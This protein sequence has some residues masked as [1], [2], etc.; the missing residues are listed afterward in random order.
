MAG[1][2]AIL[3][4]GSP[5]LN[6]K[7]AK[8]LQILADFLVD[9]VEGRRFAGVVLGLSGGID[10]AVS[11]AVAARALGP[12]RVTGLFMPYSQS[13][14]RSE[15]DVV[16]LAGRL[17]IELVKQP[18]TPF[19][20]CFFAVIPQGS[21]VRKGNVL[22]RLRMIVLFDWSHK[23]KR[24]VLG[25]SNK[26]E[27][28]L[29]YGTWY[30]DTACSM[31]AIGDLYKTQVRQLARYLRIPRSILGKT[32]SAD[33]W[34]GQTDEGEIGMSYALMDGILY[35]LFDMGM[36]PREVQE[37]GFEPKL[38]RRIVRLVQAN[39]FKSMLPEIARLNEK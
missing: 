18:L 24:L 36:S 13:D 14:P 32:P 20:D 22:A 34:P 12:Q 16:L 7:P 3:R 38:V 19:A 6:I 23:T 31:N 33:L 10:S 28:L 8:T 2:K 30:G 21:R 26:T 4:A 27:I 11:A 5:E 17:N 1:K 39:R 15:K 9:R 29:G 35:R 37:A 25:T